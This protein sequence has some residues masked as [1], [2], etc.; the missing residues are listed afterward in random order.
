[1]CPHLVQIDSLYFHII[2]GLLLK[3]KYLHYHFIYIKNSPFL[4]YGRAVGSHPHWS[5]WISSAFLFISKRGWK[6]IDKNWFAFSR[7][8]TLQMHFLTIW[9]QNFKI[10]SPSSTILAPH[11]ARVISQQYVLAVTRLLLQ[12]LVNGFFGKHRILL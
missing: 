11:G 12:Q 6:D 4:Q 1:M 2:K 8:L 3:D 9:R 5:S 7:N 10:F